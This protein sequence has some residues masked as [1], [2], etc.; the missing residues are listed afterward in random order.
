[1]YVRVASDDP[2]MKPVDA[3]F[4]SDAVQDEHFEE[5]DSYVVNKDLEQIL[6]RKFD[7]HILP[8]LALM[9]LF[10]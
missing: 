10:K 8:L 7:F 2:G 5:L 3:A 1:L 4:A 6:L 9:Y